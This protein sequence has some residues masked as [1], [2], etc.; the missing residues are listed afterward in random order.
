VQQPKV[1]YGRQKQLVANLA[2]Q[3]ILPDG[4]EEEKLP[5]W[6]SPELA[7]CQLAVKWRP[8]KK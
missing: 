6:N 5:R 8:V 7:V 2:A 1:N 3:T 4:L